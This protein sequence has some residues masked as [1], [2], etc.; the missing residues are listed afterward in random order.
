M[1]PRPEL[2]SNPW[3]ETHRRALLTIAR[4]GGFELDQLVV[5]LGTRCT[6]RRYRQFAQGLYRRAA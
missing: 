6:V 5:A 1:H 4:W 2:L 3:A